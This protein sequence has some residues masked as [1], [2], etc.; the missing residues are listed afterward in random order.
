M[1]SPIYS[2]FDYDGETELP[3]EGL[4][5]YQGRPHYFWVRDYLGEPATAIF[6]V[7][8]ADQAL[9][10]AITEQEAIWRHWDAAYH[11]GETE[12]ETHPARPG[13][14]P[15]FSELALSIQELARALRV[16]A[17]P[18]EGVVSVTAQYQK[19]M[20]TFVGH[21]WP[22]PGMRSAELEITWLAPKAA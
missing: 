11:A 6:D 22:C 4:V 14:N 5:D 7:A 12:L 18:I 8:P 2:Y 3:E 1:A 10:L 20:Q 16:S 9:I 13:N 19:R 15:R 21:K 17:R